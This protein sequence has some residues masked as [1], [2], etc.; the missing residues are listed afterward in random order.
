MRVSDSIVV[1]NRLRVSCSSL[2]SNR[3]TREMRHL[4]AVLLALLFITANSPLVRAQEAVS[5]T[6]G[7]GTTSSTSA[8]SSSSSTTTTGELSTGTTAPSTAVTS[9]TG[10][11]TVTGGPSGVGAFSPTPNKIYAR[12]SGGFADNSNTKE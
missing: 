11:P 8:P 10:Q 6:G 1:I 3:A 2:G 5:T 4:F 7:S 12:V 9:S